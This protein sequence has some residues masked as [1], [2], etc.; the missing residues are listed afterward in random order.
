MEA[1]LHDQEKHEH[2]LCFFHDNGRLVRKTVFCEY[3]RD[4]GV[5]YSC[6]WEGRMIPFRE[7]FE[8]MASQGLVLGRRNLVAALREHSY[9]R[10]RSRPRS[11]HG[12]GS[13][14]GMRGF[15]KDHQE[16]SPRN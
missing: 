5:R 2:G 12:F 9:S 3:L 16:F 14:K 6:K 1:I 11:K 4:G 10:S 13:P 7:F 15:R 8:I